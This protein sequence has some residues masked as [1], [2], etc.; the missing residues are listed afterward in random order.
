MNYCGID[1]AKRK[2]SAMVINA[3]A[4]TVKQNFTFRNNRQGFDKL[5]ETLDPFSEALMVALE[6]TGHYWLALYDVLS[7]A[8]YQVVVFN[9]LQVH[10]YQRSGIRKRK[11]D[12]IASFWIADFARISN[13]ETTPQQTPELIQLRDL[14]RFRYRL[15]ENMGNCKRRILSILDKVFPE[16]ETLF[17]SVFLASSRQLLAQAVTAQEFADFDLSEL[18][19]L[20]SSASRGRFGQ[21]KAE[22]IQTTAR[23]SI[24]INFLADSV[25]IQMRCLLQQLDLLEAQ[26]QEIDL[27]ID[28]LMQLLPQHITS[29]PGIGL[30]TGAAILGEIGDI[31]RFDSPDK[32]VAY[33]G[34]DATVYQSGEFEAAETHMSKRGSPYLR[35]ALWQAASMSIQ[36]DPQLKQ[37]YQRK[38][39]EGKHH[40]TAIGAVSRK[41][42]ARIFVILKENRPYEIRY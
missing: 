36:Y 33:A 39:A 37:Y 20:L 35:Q 16:Y 1:I 8:G 41:L 27:A 11:N 26:R 40:G 42:V 5:L 2:H 29:I 24:G 3:E 28:N 6:A 19:A 18:T 38:K 14:S 12:R 31:H 23:R 17:S 32:L 34:I 13:P 25:R 9:P 10:A 30:T 21:E 15:T 4:E 22:A 7:S